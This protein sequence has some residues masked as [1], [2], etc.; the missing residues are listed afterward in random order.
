MLKC[1]N[2]II[3]WYP[4]VSKKFKKIYL[5]F[6]TKKPIKKWQKIEKEVKKRFFSWFE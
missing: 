1:V 4:N 5:E 6:Y 3:I 2:V